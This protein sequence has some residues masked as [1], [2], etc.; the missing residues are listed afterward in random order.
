[1]LFGFENGRSACK[2]VLKKRGLFSTTIC[3]RPAL[4]LTDAD[5]QKI[6]ALGET[7]QLF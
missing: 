5:Q 1:L 2:L 4:P 3:A 7:L 6:E